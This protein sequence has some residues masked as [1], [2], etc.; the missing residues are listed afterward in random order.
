MVLHMAVG[1]KMWKNIH[2]T[3]LL[4]GTLFGDSIAPYP[5]SSSSSLS[6]ESILL[7]FL[8]SMQAEFE[9]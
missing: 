8:E 1:D 6:S 4:P 7:C 2:N 9:K 5:A 3:T